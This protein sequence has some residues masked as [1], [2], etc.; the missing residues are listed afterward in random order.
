VKRKS[1]GRSGVTSAGRVRISPIQTLERSVELMA[2]EAAQARLA[3]ARK[4]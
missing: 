3:S 1:E 4:L 2:C